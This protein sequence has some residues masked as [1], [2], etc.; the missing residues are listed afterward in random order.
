MSQTNSR[1]R[2]AN[3]KKNKEKENKEKM[4]Y[5]FQMPELQS[6]VQE[7]RRGKIVNEWGVNFILTEWAGLKCPWQVLNVFFDSMFGL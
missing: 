2:H 7:K 1:T 6:P 5:F 4:E 3:K